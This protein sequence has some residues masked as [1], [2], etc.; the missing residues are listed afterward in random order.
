MFDRQVFIP[1]TLG[2][3]FGPVEG[4]VGVLRDIDLSGLPSGP[5]DTR[6]LLNQR[7]RGV[8]QSFGV[9]AGAGQ[10]AGKKT[11][12]LR[13]QGGEQVFLLNLSV[14]VIDGERLRA[15]NRFGGFLGKL[16]GV[17]DRNLL[18]DGDGFF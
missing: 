17:H 7:A 14:A 15:L 4:A 11:A 5:G 8:F 3:G 6:Q 12:F 13:K 9:N 1:E 18:L 10:N 16:I 2:V